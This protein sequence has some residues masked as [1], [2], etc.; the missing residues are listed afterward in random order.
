LRFYAKKYSLTIDGIDEEAFEVLE[1]MDF[2]GNVRELSNLIERASYL[3]KA[4][5]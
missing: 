1:K 3:A 2:P 5:I 4:T